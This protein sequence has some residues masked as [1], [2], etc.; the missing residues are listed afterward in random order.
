[1][2]IPEARRINKLS[3][4]SELMIYLGRQS[5]MKGDTFMPKGLVLFYSD[6]A[7]FDEDMYPNCGSVHPKQT[8]QINEP[9]SNQ[10]D[11]SFDTTPGDSDDPP[12]EPKQE[13]HTPQP[14]RVEQVPSQGPD[15]LQALPPEPEPVP[16]PEPE[17]PA[18]PRRSGQIRRPPTRPDNVYGDKHPTKITKDIERTCNWRH[19]VGDEPGSS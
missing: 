2:H 3:P 13:R 16:E 14:D 6:T 18:H 15:E 4:K 7:L 12:P 11:P 17:P 1:M 10:P 9:P 5:G 8:T 19:L